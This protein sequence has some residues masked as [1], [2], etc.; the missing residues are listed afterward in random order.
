MNEIAQIN[1]MGREHKL[2]VDDNGKIIATVDI[3]DKSFV[4]KII[5]EHNESIINV[6]GKGA[7]AGASVIK[8]L[9]K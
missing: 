4:D 1:G 8:N 6:Y 9:I 2:I 7:E 3:L 5:E